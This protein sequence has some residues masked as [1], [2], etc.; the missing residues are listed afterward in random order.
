MCTRTLPSVSTQSTR[1]SCEAPERTPHV[2]CAA[3]SRSYHKGPCKLLPAKPQDPL[4]EAWLLSYTDF[5]TPDTLSLAQMGSD[6]FEPLKARPAFFDAAG[7]RV[8]QLFAT[9]QDGTRVPYFV[10]WPKGAQADGVVMYRQRSKFIDRL[11]LEN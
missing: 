8:E 11:Y 9:S 10:V 7:M 2:P 4:A 3:A 6:T 5:L 1:P